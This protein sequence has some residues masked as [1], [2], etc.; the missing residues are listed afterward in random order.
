MLTLPVYAISA[1]ETA[2]PCA[3]CHGPTGVSHN[4][5]W[6][7]LAG[8]HPTYL[9]KQIR[10]FKS[11][12][13]RQSSLMA[14]SMLN[15]LSEQDIQTLAVFY[16][17]QPFPKNKTPKK[18][19]SRGERLYRGGDRS[20]Q[21][22]ACIACHGPRGTGNEQAGFPAVRSQQPNYT[23]QQLKLFK[24]KARTNDLHAIMR[25]ISQHMNDDDM[26]AVAYYMAGLH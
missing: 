18:Y 25:D 12:Q 15:D 16:G 5:E 2:K 22:T 20:K 24:S 10:D 26:R 4:P 23:I 11:G 19:L 21:I 3:A 13:S 6:P 9:V 7:N 8:Q 14:P 1:L 17:N